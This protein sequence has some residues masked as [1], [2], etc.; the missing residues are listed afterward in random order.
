MGEDSMPAAPS[1]GD[2]GQ[3]PQEWY[4][5]A[6]GSS[7]QVVCRGRG[8]GVR[9]GTCSSLFSTLGQLVA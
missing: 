8:G 2:S 1:P 7:G 9:A 6:A 5:Q 3:D 4:P